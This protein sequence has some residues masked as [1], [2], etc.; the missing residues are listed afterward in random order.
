MTG[1]EC[2]IHG[3]LVDVTSV[4]FLFTLG[5]IWG[6]ILGRRWKRKSTPLVALAS[7]ENTGR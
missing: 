5:F 6:F 7:N 3:P 4:G 1:Q 2:C